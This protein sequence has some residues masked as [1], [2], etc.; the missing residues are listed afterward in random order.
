MIAFRANYIFY[1]PKTHALFS[2]SIKINSWNYFLL[3]FKKK[4]IFFFS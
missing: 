4:K 1:C 2:Y 3:I